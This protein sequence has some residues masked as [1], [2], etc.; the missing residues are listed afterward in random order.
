MTSTRDD[1]LPPGADFALRPP[2]I[3][4]AGRRRALKGA[5]FEKLAARLM[6]VYG[7]SQL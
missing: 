2:T 3:E 5:P 1:D 4:Q 7:S 6:T